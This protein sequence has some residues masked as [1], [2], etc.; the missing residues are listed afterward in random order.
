LL[1]V[2]LGAVL[3]LLWPSEER[4]DR[5]TALDEPPETHAQRATTL[6]EPVRPL[7]SG[8]T[9]SSRASEL[10][11]QPVE[12]STPA[13]TSSARPLTRLRGYLLRSSDRTG[14]AGAEL[15]FHVDA[16]DIMTQ[17]VTDASGAFETEPVIPPGIVRAWAV[18]RELERSE[19]LVT[20]ISDAEP[21]HEIELVWIEPNASVDVLVTQDGAPA[22]AWVDW[23]RSESR[24]W[25][26]ADTDPLGRA[27]LDV[28]R[29]MPGATLRLAAHGESSASPWKELV[30]PWPTEVVQLELEPMGSVLVR[31]RDRL[32]RPMQGELVQILDLEARHEGRTDAFGQAVV[33]RVLAGPARVFVTWGE[34]QTID[35]PAG[36]RLE[37][38]VVV[39]NERLVAGRVLDEDGAGL[40]EVR[41]YAYTDGGGY[42]IPTEEDGSFAIRCEESEQLG[43]VRVEMG[44]EV[45]DDRFEPESVTVRAGTTDLVFRRTSSAE[46]V[47]V[48]I[49]AVDAR[50]LELVSD[51]RFLLFRELYPGSG[52]SYQAPD[53]FAC[54]AC[55]PG[56][57]LR[58]LLRAPGHRD[59]TIAWTELPDDVR[60]GDV[61]A[62]ATLR[63]TLEPGF[64]WTVRV[65]DA[66]TEEPIAGAS[67]LD[68]DALLATTDISGSARIVLPQWPAELRVVG[69]GLDET[70][71]CQELMDDPR[72]ELRV[73]RDE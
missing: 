70:W 42:S 58:F 43:P 28:S 35:V 22:K 6:L 69:D 19:F 39:E 71:S 34:E 68:G 45:E 72:I 54:C 51:A 38:D 24:G 41:V 49:A 21:M 73:Y 66:E 11:S 16:E 8:E 55:K 18:A 26:R 53:G 32:G 13:A 48:T 31:L 25:N 4:G 50:S 52:D 44:T 12:A 9:S 46:S 30:F 40:G 64:D 47:E 14:V 61:R 1:L 17:V 60:A 37:I 56:D 15:T 65:I 63:L 57:D 3:A 20:E 23:L 5:G 2:V 33:E 36:R 67:V 10:D 62:G 29:M 27:H 7:S 59:R